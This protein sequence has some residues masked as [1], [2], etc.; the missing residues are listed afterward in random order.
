M[1]F[2]T[3]GTPARAST[4]APYNSGTNNGGSSQGTERS[5]EALIIRRLKQEEKELNTFIISVRV[6]LLHWHGH[7]YSRLLR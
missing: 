6:F 3:N 2:N 1:S 4:K 7:E 5:N